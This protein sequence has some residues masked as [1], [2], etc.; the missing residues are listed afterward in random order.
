MK[1]EEGW[2]RDKLQ[3]E[4]IEQNKGVEEEKGRIYFYISLEYRQL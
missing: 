3:T 4:K 1:K 2:M